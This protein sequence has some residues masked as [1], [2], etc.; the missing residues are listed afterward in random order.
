MKL[1]HLHTKMMFLE[2]LGLLNTSDNTWVVYSEVDNPF[3]LIS[4]WDEEI[5][6]LE[7]IDDTLEDFKIFGFYYPNF[8]GQ[9]F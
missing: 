3:D 2:I 4:H 8:W 9:N 7:C 6:T 1:E 5:P